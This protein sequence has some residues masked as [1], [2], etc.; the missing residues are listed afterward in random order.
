MNSERMYYR[1]SDDLMTMD[2]YFMDC[3]G[4]TGWQIY[5][6]NDIDYKGRD[7]SSHATHRNHFTGDTYKS[8]CWNSR[9]NTLDEAKAIASL[10][11]DTTSRYI[12]L[13]KNGIG[14]DEIVKKLL[15]E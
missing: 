11:A 6:I 10:W 2:F 7:T 15:A 5:I 4:S 14:F 9:I 13:G 3:G 1:T 8:I 12:M